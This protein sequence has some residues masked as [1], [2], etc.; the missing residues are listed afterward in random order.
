M[1]ILNSTQTKNSLCTLCTVCTVFFFISAHIFETV[2]KQCI[3]LYHLCTDYIIDYLIDIIDSAQ[4]AQK[5]RLLVHAKK[6][7]I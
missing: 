6:T 2:H 3:K 7:T 4:S 5:F 1:S